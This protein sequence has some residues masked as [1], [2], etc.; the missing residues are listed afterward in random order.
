MGSSDICPLSA[1][2]KKKSSKFQINLAGCEHLAIEKL[3][4]HA[5]TTAT[6]SGPV[7]I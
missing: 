2:E 6:G 7:G 1:Q 5:I 4:T 3:K